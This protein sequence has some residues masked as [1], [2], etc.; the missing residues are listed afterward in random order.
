MP[1][2]A[3]AI[4]AVAIAWLLACLVAVVWLAPSI[5]VTWDERA[6]ALYG[7]AILRWF[8]D[9]D[10]QALAFRGDSFYGGGFDL[11][12]ALVRRGASDPYPVL[13]VLG[14]LVAW[15]GLLV[16]W[17]LARRLGPEVGLLALVL[18]TTAP[19]YVGHAFAN[20]KDL[21]LAV[22]YAAGLLGV[23]RWFEAPRPTWKTVASVGLLIGLAACVRVSGL[24]ALAILLVG[25]GGRLLRCARA[26]GR[27]AALTE[28]D[29]VVPAVV[30]VVAVAWVVMLAAWPWAQ[31]NPLVRP[32][33]SLANL[34]D[35]QAHDRTMP[36]AGEVMRT[37]EPRRDYAFHYLA[38][39]LPLPL[40]AGVLLAAVQAGRA[41]ATTLVVAGAAVMVPLSLVL[42]LNPVLY[43]GMRHLLFVV[44][45][46]CVLAAWGIVEAVRRWARAWSLWVL[47]GLLGCGGALVMQARALVSLHPMQTVWFNPLVGGLAGAQGR[48]SLDYYGFTYREAADR[49]RDYVAA[50]ASLRGVEHIPIAAAMPQWAARWTFGAP[51]EP[52]R[53]PAMNEPAPIFYIAYTRG[54]AHTK[55]PRAATVATVE[56]DGVVLAVVKDLRKRGRG[57]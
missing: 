17:R 31:Q 34:V 12:G 30:G 21:P 50:D 44:P 10:P 25:A 51:F 13:H 53:G 18:L 43:D 15:S 52:T 16:V 4:D 23:V 6:H 22:G 55:H 9:G 26:Q 29:R 24:F 14:G 47:A 37:L 7:D 49:L 20:P 56:R 57:G 11:L 1:G 39:K 40:L 36:F 3:R 45:P 19:V 5:P 33:L 38:F 28:A 42:L 32:L 48:Y 8:T 41:R 27:A 2:R 35:F 46:L 54:D